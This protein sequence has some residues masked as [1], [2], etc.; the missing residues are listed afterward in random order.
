MIQS[1]HWMHRVILH[2]VHKCHGF[3]LHPSWLHFFVSFL[4]TICMAWPIKSNIRHYSD[5]TSRQRITKSYPAC[6]WL[7]R[8]WDDTAAASLKSKRSCASV[9]CVSVEEPYLPSLETVLRTTFPTT[10]SILPYQNVMMF[11]TFHVGVTFLECC[12]LWCAHPFF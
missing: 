10:G 6:F 1:K 9:P 12:G 2:V 11:N 8:M 3:L 5:V 4:F 7:C